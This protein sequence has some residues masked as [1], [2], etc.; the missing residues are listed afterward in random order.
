MHNISIGSTRIKKIFILFLAF[1]LT[2]YV[3]KLGEFFSFSGLITPLI[4]CILMFLFFFLKKEKIIINA[5][6]LLLSISFVY[7]L[8]SVFFNNISIDHFML[9]LQ[10]NLLSIGSYFMVRFTSFQQSEIR[11]L[12]KFICLIFLNSIFLVYFFFPSGTLINSS[13]RLGGNYFNSVGLAYSTLVVFSS[14]IT[15]LLYLKEEKL[16]WRV[17]YVISFILSLC[18]LFLSGSRGPFG[19][20]IL[21]LLL[22]GI[23][24][25]FNLSLIKKLLF[26]A[27]IAPL[28]FYFIINIEIDTSYRALNFSVNDSV[29]NRFV[30]YKN[31]YNLISESPFLGDGFSDFQSKNGYPHN[32]ILEM[33]LY[34][35]FIGFIFSFIIIL[36]LIYLPFMIIFEKNI[37]KVSF[38]IIIFI[39]LAPKLASTNIGMSKELLIFL[40]LYITNKNVIRDGF[41]HNRF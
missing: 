17:I 20:A 4:F 25:F 29:M 40:S 35:G 9:L 32:I 18:I 10:F 2:S 23:R 38:F 8:F 24:V 39:M 12:M 33:L 13:L 16:F 31:A 3:A 37:F 27:I 5:L 36:S 14:S 34:F 19:I 1:Y 22:I 28:V 11:L 6:D 21:T 30:T 15:C 41:N 7:S 26:I